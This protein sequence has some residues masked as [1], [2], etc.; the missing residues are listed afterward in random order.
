MTRIREE[1]DCNSWATCVC[2]WGVQYGK[3]WQALE[4]AK[5]C[6]RLYKFVIITLQLCVFV[7]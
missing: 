7:K 2:V 3:N 6:T 4:A 5:C 1:E